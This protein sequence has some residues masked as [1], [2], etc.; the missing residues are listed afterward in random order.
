MTKQ[1]R[2]QLMGLSDRCEK[3][4]VVLYEASLAESG[5]EQGQSH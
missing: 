2:C 4:I 3:G 5:F 1:Q